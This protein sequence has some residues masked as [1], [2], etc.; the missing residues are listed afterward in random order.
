MTIIYDIGT[1]WIE[2]FDVSLTFTGAGVRIDSAA[3]PLGRGGHVL[4][5]S[6]VPGSNAVGVENVI[7]GIGNVSFGQAITTF[8]ISA[9]SLSTVAAYPSS[10]TITVMIWMSP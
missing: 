6:V 3:I 2:R 9:V 10:R 8:S 4:G 7:A 1:F 5:A